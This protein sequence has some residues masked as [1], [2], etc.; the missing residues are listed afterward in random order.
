AGKIGLRYVTQQ[1]GCRLCRRR[2][3]LRGRIR[4][5]HTDGNLTILRAT[6]KQRAGLCR[7]IKIDIA[8]FAR[9]LGRR[10]NRGEGAYRAS[11]PT[12]LKVDIEKCLVGAVVYMRNLQRSA[13]VSSG[14]LAPTGSF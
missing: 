10:R 1:A 11:Q 2:Y 3:G 4:R 13:D 8:E 6:W 7:V 14:L 12:A 9:S 5:A